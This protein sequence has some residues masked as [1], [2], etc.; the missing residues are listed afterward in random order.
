MSF[1]LFGYIFQNLNKENSL[2]L[3]LTLLL[4]QRVVYFS[5]IFYVLYSNKFHIFNYIS[6]VQQYITFLIKINTFFYLRALKILG[7]ETIK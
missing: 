5:K 2:R 3:H 6:K 1:V 7:V 4:K